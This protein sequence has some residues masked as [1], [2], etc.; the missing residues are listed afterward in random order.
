MFGQDEAYFSAN[1]TLVI[2]DLEEARKDLTNVY[3]L[4][5]EKRGYTSVPKEIA[6]MVNLK[7]LDLSGNQIRDLG[8]SFEKLTNLETLKLNNNHLVSMPLESLSNCKGLKELYVNNNKIRRLENTINQFKHLER[9]DV[10]NNSISLIAADIVLNKLKRFKVQ[11]NR[12]KAYPVFLNQSLG[13]VTLNMNANQLTN[14]D[15]VAK[16]TKLTSLNIS[17]NPIKS[18]HAIMNLPQLEFLIADWIDLSTEANT[19]TVKLNS[20]R[21]IS[22]EH[23]QLTAIPSWIE[24]CKRLE[25]FSL[26]SNHIKEIPAFLYEKKR[27][28]K[29]WLAG[30]SIPEIN[31]KEIKSKLKRCQVKS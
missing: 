7:S 14:I 31:L 11:N 5:L 20:L 12:I 8:D 23:C 27:L 28:K 21:V 29:L 22:V 16:L 10:G 18:I 15:D 25:E 24:G 17:D 2:E 13:L 6:K 3:H 4:R 1:R 26:I 19:S 30:N 9:L